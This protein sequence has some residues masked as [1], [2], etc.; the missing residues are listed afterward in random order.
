MEFRR[1]LFRSKPLENAIAQATSPEEL[2][3]VI[4]NVDLSTI[5]SEE[6]TSLI[7]NDAIAELDS[8]ELQEVFAEIDFNNFTE[9]E[10]NKVILTL[11]NADTKVKEAFEEEIN[12]Y[13]SNTF[14]EYVP[15]GSTVSV[16]TR[17]AIIAI[18]AAISTVSIATSSASA[19]GGE[20]RRK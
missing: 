4:N 3:N 20:S 17:R 1:V 11:T 8:S 15:A 19:S 14:D 2:K 5:N 12:I 13:S 16:A 7:N 9:Q 18:S 6:L 10:L